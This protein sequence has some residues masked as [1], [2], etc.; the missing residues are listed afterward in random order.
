MLSGTRLVV[1]TALCCT[2]WLSW[3]EVA[4]AEPTAQGQK[5]ASVRFKRALDLWN[6]GHHDAALAEFQ[7]AYEIAPMYQVLYNIGKGHAV[8]GNA[9]KAVDTL[10]K[11]LSEGGQAISDKKR[12]E[13]EELIQQ[14][15]QRIARLYV[16]VNV[17]GADILLEGVHVATTPL[18]KPLR[19]T[20]GKHTVGALA[21][22]CLTEQR[23]VELA[24]NV[25]EHVMFNLKPKPDQQPSVSFRSR[26]KEVDVLVDGESVGKTPFP[27][28]LGMTP[29]KHEIVARRPG[30]RDYKDTLTL[31][32]GNKQEIQISLQRDPGALPEQ[33]GKLRLTL[34]E[35]PYALQVDGE[36]MDAMGAT[37]ALPVGSHEVAVQVAER[38]PFVT[39]VSVPAGTGTLELR[40][41]LVWTPEARQDRLD[42]ATRQRNWGFALAGAG[43]VVG[44][45]STVFF[46]SAN[47]DVN[48]LEGEIE[49]I[50][51]ELDTLACAT[52][53]ASECFEPLTAQRQ[54]KQTDLDAAKNRR[55]GGLI[56]LGTGVASAAVG[57]VLILAAPSE[58]AISR[59][60]SARNRFDVRVGAR[61][62]RIMMA[63]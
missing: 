54:Q 37:L 24:G 46:L 22:C 38:Q 32:E 2:A 42:A 3:A 57:A 14:Q 33:L 15:R 40:P 31:T 59:G 61:E 47:S 6:E 39:Q 7:R 17:D 55:L 10:E 4:I 53:E 21:P 28:P 60:A 19:L 5:E 49:E 58:E 13:V 34:P 41:D 45:I 56:G 30:Y 25:D 12:K 27:G 11:Y 36:S 52:A 8:I 29:G 20:A 16:D 48:A 26:L 9:V 50:R 18:T 35:A 1:I 44:G 62:V 23:T 63:F 43:A 51:R